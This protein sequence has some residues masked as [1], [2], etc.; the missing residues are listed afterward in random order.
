MTAGLP[1]CC[2]LQWREVH[3]QGRAADRMLCSSSRRCLL[4]LVT[5]C[6]SLL[7]NR[8]SGRHTCS[9]LRPFSRVKIESA[10]INNYIIR[11]L[12]SRHFV[13]TRWSVHISVLPTLVGR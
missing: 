1:P 7:R 9:V 8:F 6:P 2:W 5:H 3:L 13:Q 10:F 11:G 12:T 4:S